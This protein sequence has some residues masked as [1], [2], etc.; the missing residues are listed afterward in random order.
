M[1]EHI[2]KSI[3]IFF[4][5]VFSLTVLGMAAVASIAAVY[6]VLQSGAFREVTLVVVFALGVLLAAASMMGSATEEE[7]I[8]RLERVE[9]QLA[10]LVDKV[11]S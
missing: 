8:K 5:R 11:E 7:I 2:K 9:T 6:G 4:Y 1:K 3:G 10:R